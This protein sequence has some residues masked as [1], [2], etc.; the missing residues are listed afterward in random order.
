MKR[1]LFLLALLLGVSIGV[2]APDDF[3]HRQALA[4]ATQATTP[5]DYAKAANLFLRMLREGDQREVNFLNGA[6]CAFFARRPAVALE[7]LR[8]AERLYGRSAES[9][10]TLMAVCALMGR[11]VPQW[12][13]RLSFGLGERVSVLCWLTG[14][15]LALGAVLGRRMKGLTGTMAVVTLGVAIAV[16]VSFSRESWATIPDDLPE[17]TEA[18]E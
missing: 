6:S 13:P 17:V 5:E 18:A 11:P 4:M 15:T 3:V 9:D 16:A 7:L 14:I 8:R 1:K 2:A 12:P 10:Q